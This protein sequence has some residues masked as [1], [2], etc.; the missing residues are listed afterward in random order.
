[1]I[2]GIDETVD[3]GNAVDRSVGVKLVPDDA[4]VS[5]YRS[6]LKSLECP[7]R[8]LALPGINSAISAQ[9]T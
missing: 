1:M 3:V 8:R 6:L 5:G 7:S 2:I 4:T 9:V